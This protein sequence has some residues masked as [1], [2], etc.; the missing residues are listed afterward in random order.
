MKTA[1]EYRHR[2]C[3]HKAV[4]VVAQMRGRESSLRIAITKALQKIVVIK[5]L[6]CVAVPALLSG[7]AQS[8]VS[9]VVLVDFGQEFDLGTVVATD[10]RVSVSRGEKTECLRVETGTREPWPGVTLR[11]PGGSWNVA[12]HH[13]IAVPVKN[14]GTNRVSV[15]CRVDNPGADGIKNCVTSRVS[16]NPGQSG[17]IGVELKRTSEEKLGGKLF[18]MRGYPVKWGGA[19]T[20]NP[21]NVTQLIVFVSKPG[22]SHQFELGTIRARGNYTPPTAFVTD[23]EPFFPFIDTFGQYKHKDWPGKVHSADELVAR[24]EREAVKLSDDSGPKGWDKFGGWADGPQ[25]EAKGFFYTAKHDGKWWLVDPEGRLFWSHGID[26]VR[27]LDYT[28]VEERDSWFEDFPGKN[29]ELARYFTEG[30]YALKGHYA[31]RRPRSYSFAGAN[32]HRKYGPDW[33]RVYPEVIHRRLR[34]WG[35]NTIANWSDEGL[36]LMRRTPYTDAIGSHGARMIEGSEGY[37]GKFPDVFD[38]TFEAS[39]RRQMQSKKGKS[40]GDPW[41]IGYF[42]DNEMSWGDEVSLAMAAAVSPADQAAKKAFRDFLKAKYGD[43]ER[44]NSVWGASH[45]SWDAFLESTAKPD[46]AKAG[47]DLRAFYT[48]AAERYFRT[49]R[50]V[51]K[52]VAPDQLYLGCRFAWVNKLAAAAAAKYCD[53][54]SYNLYQR[55]VAEF[56]FN[57]GRDVPLIIGEFHFGALDRGM[58]H[59]GLVPVADQ[60]SRAASY[61]DY[62][63][64]ALRHRQIVGTHW[65]Q[66]QDE[67]T[68][69]RVYD[70][71]NYQIG[72]VDVADTPYAETIEASRAVARELYLLRLK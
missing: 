61:R 72:F 60:A 47:D 7:T 46:V 58:F 57:G 69:G 53:V 55:S 64:G 67:P 22:S 42:S 23:A 34:S 54:V 37:W 26:C 29:P 32:L 24:R 59:T 44:L 18:G 40:A 3:G 39:L 65:F 12:A 28:P 52:E 6:L 2:C 27:M 16:L 70:E 56:E 9:G 48:V 43:I 63:Q 49:V 35:L 68:T 36:R 10:A 17:V 14:I 11:A 1:I 19:G 31:G 25:F 4:G 33:Q 41:C 20:I 13:E 45:G 21:S 71:E 30:G 51:I 38:G 8:A 15:F 62:V 66:Y 50:Q 5:L